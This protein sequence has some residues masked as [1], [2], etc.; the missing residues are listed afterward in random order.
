M[1]TKD[2]GTTSFTKQ[3]VPNK[4]EQTV[5]AQQRF[6]KHVPAEKVSIRK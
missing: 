6:G 2:N 1:D 3:Q 5:A 4:Q